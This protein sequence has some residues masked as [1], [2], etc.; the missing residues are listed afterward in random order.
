MKTFA[1]H[2][3]SFTACV[4]AVNYTQAIRAALLMWH[5]NDWESDPPDLGV[6][7]ICIP[8]GF[9]SGSNDEA[10]FAHTETYLKDLGLLAAS[11]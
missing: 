3:G 8:S 1:V 7:T 11:T 2:S 4:D 5:Q 9:H 6:L 10:V